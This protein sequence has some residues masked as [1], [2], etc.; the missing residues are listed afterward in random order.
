MGDYGLRISKTGED[1][2]TADPED[3]YFSSH[4]HNFKELSSGTSTFKTGDDT[5]LN[6][7]I[8]DSATTITVDS[9]ANY[10]SAGV[11][12]V[13]GGG[14]GNYEA[15]KYT[16]TTGTTFTGCTRGYWSTAASAWSDNDV[17]TAGYTLR[18]I[19]THGLSYYP[20]AFCWGLESASN[21]TFALPYIG[22]TF[23][24]N[25]FMTDT[26]IKATLI[27]SATTVPPSGGETWTVKYHCMYDKIKS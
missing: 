16:G 14:I 9:T 11:F 24:F 2:V 19:Y 8:T 10:S 21:N 13:D 25:Y 18:N 12:F 26:H 20:I 15:I 6:G 4:Y 7:G 17:V 3:L 22:G 23:S 27:R 5:A 1:V